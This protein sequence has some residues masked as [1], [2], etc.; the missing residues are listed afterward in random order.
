MSPD[1]R[2]RLVRPPSGGEPGGRGGGSRLKTAGQRSLSS[3]QWLERQL[4]DPY[5]QKAKAEGYRSRAAFKLIEIDERYRL[6]RRGARVI[7]LGAA[8]GGWTE[9]ALRRGAGAVVG[10]D[11]LPV[12]A[13]S[14][15]TLI[16]ADFT[17]EG[18]PERL[19]QALGGPPDLVLSDMAHN[20]VGHRRTD[21][22]KVLQL[23]EAAADFAIDALPSGGAFLAKAFQG[24]ATGALLA[25]LK[26]TFGQVR[27]VKP[28]ASRAD[29]AEVYLVATGFRGEA[30][31]G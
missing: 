11:L 12:P 15:A 9:A 29:S 8:P 22:L 23:V 1:D 30:A 5:V 25:R 3:Q 2:R 4:A 10:V 7:D 24:G 20:T 19:L 18:V 21:H 13:I 28:R 14:G 17:D 27:H 26:A 6:I 16:E 31:V